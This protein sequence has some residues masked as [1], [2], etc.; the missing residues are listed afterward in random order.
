MAFCYIVLLYLPFAGICS[1]KI[2][3]DKGHMRSAEIVGEKYCPQVADK[4]GCHGCP[5]EF[6]SD[7]VKRHCDEIIYCRTATKEDYAKAA[8]QHNI[9]EPRNPDPCAVVMANNP[10]CLKAI[11][12]YVTTHTTLQIAVRAG[13]HGY[14]GASTASKGVVVDVSRF[15]YVQQQE[16]EELMRVGAGISLGELYYKLWDSTPRSLYPGGSCLTVGLSGLTLG[17][18]QGIIGRKYGL[19]SDQMVE[20]KMVDAAGEVV[21]TNGETNPDLFWALQGGGNGN[22]GVVYEFTLRR[23]KIPDVSTDYFVYFHEPKEWH[24]VLERWQRLVTGKEFS[25]DHDTWSQLAIS[26]GF[27]RVAFH[28]SGGHRKQYIEVLT[29]GVTPSGYHPG[30]QYIE[31]MYTPDNFSGSIAS[32]GD[33]VSDNQCGTTGDLERCLQYPL[34]CEG[35][36]FRRHSGFQSGALSGDG[37]RTILHYMLEVEPKPCLNATLLLDTLGGRINEI[38]PD[39]TAFPHRSNMVAYQFMSVFDYT[40]DESQMKEWLK[41]FHNDM[42]QYMAKG[43]YCNYANPDLV[44]HNQHYF[45]GNY[46]K[47]VGIKKKYDPKNIFRHSQS[48]PT[49][50][51]DSVIL[52]YWPYTAGIFLVTLF[53]CYYVHSRGRSRLWL[54]LFVNLFLCV[55]TYLLIEKL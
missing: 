54:C 16:G 39:S 53:L 50:T 27:L 35:R 9:A 32:W 17:G 19:S 7:D 25:E 36:A 23:Y 13:R 3:P 49:E 48:I 12:R 55:C 22:F 15:N 41:R 43:S 52:P 10:E 40:C 34:E 28:I 45:L 11:V 4:P 33:C 1:A 21:V 26:P 42:S 18:G 5:E 44:D 38:Q 24:T 8:F 47:L 29:R 6:D 2:Y 51:V 30:D 46:D 31:C 37:I 14:I 20:A